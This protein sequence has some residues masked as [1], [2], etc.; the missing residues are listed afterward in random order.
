LLNSPTA[1]AQPLRRSGAL[2]FHRD[3]QRARRLAFIVLVAASLPSAGRARAVPANPEPRL[4]VQPDGVA[5]ERVLRGD[6]HDSRFETLDGFTIVLREEV[7]GAGGAP[8]VYATLDDAGRLAPTELVVGDVDP[9]VLGLV[10]HLSRLDPPAPPPRSPPP[11]SLA[12]DVPAVG[13]GGLQ[14]P[15][16]GS[17]KH[18]V[19]LAAFADHWDYSNVTID[20]RYG[21]PSDRYVALMNER[22]HTADGAVGSVADYYAE[23]TNGQLLVDSKVSGWLRLPASQAVYANADGSGRDDGGRLA[24]DALAALEAAS[25]DFRTVDDDGDGWV[26]MLTIIHSGW[27]AA[28]G[29]NGAAGY[30]WSHASAIDPVVYDG[31]RAGRYTTISALRGADGDRAIVRIG[32]ACHE[33]GHFLGVR[34]FYD[35]DGPAFGQGEGLGSWSVMAGGSWNGGGTRPGPFD[36]YTRSLLGWIVPSRVHSLPPES[37]LVF[38]LPR[39]GETTGGVFRIDDGYA[40]GE[41]LL[42]EHY[43]ETGVFHRFP[44]SEGLA[45]GVAIWHI[46]ERNPTNNKSATPTL[47]RAR[48]VEADGDQSLTSGASRA[49]VGDVWDPGGGTLTLDASHPSGGARANGGWDPGVAVIVGGEP[50]DATMTLATRTKTPHLHLPEGAVAAPGGTVALTWGAA[51]GAAWYDIELGVESPVTYVRD[52][53]ESRQRFLEDWQARGSWQRFDHRGRNAGGAADGDF[54]YAAVGLQ[55][56]SDDAPVIPPVVDFRD[57]HFVLTYQRPLWITAGSIIRW[58]E[59]R[60]LGAGNFA[61]LQ[62]RDWEGGAWTTVRRVEDNAALWWETVEVRGASLGPF[63]GKWVQLRFEVVLDTWAQDWLWPHSGLA[64]DRLELDGVVVHVPTWANTDDVPPTTTERDVTLPQTEGSW[65]LRVVPIAPDGTRGVASNAVR[66]TTSAGFDQTPPGAITNL[67]TTTIGVDAIGLSMT[68]CGD[69]GA[70]GQATLEVRRAAAA[71]TTATWDTTTLIETRAVQGGATVTLTAGGLAPL[72]TW[73]FAAR[74]RDERGLVGP[75]S[76]VVSARTKNLAPAAPTLLGPA[77]GATGV[78]TDAAL[79]WDNGA[80]TADP[81]SATYWSVVVYL[82]TDRG[83]VEGRSGAAAVLVTDALA[84]EHRP[85]AGLAPDTTYHW[86]V[87]DANATGESASAV[88]SFTTRGGDTAAPRAIDDLVVDGVYGVAASLGWTAPGDDGAGGGASARYDLRIARAPIDALGF[89]NAQPLAMSSPAPAGLADGAYLIGLAPETTYWVAVKTEDEVPNVSPISN[90]VSFTTKSVPVPDA[91]TVGSPVDGAAV[92]VTPPLVWVNGAKTGEPPDRARAQVQLFFSQER[93]RVEAMELGA[94]PDAPSALVVEGPATLTTWTPPPLAIRGTYYW[95]VID[96]N[97]GGATVGPVW[98]FRVEAADVIPPRA[99]DDLRV[100]T[101]GEDEVTIAWT[102]PGDDGASG[103][104]SAYEARLAAWSYVAADLRDAP[105]VPDVPAP[106]PGG[107]AST[108]TI[109]GLVPGTDYW[110]VLRAVDEVGGWGG[111]SAVVHF[112]TLGGAGPEPEPEAEPE[113]EPE[114]M[115][116][117]E[118][119]PM[120]EPGPEADTTIGE[121]TSVQVDGGERSD[122]GGCDAGGGADASLLGLAIALARLRA[123]R[124]RAARDR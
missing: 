85:V 15:S 76:N 48:M 104:A 41:Y 37:G 39:S 66:V 89:A 24:R 110:I 50:A 42:V 105:V 100:V 115:I 29:G 57:G 63:V 103:T 12:R 9:W 27:D 46:D 106:L 97:A 87:V 112:R 32:V 83:L 99:I 22:G 94:S 30:V 36:A 23:A 2:A 93:A 95:R 113:A 52:D 81:V 31:V 88:R 92:T 90:V 18:L 34:D 117:P 61:R 51:V 16:F 54:S 1:R 49:E 28:D 11:M 13:P 6:E 10:P 107:S 40:D 67:T 4:T 80:R 56:S 91:P 43:G 26:D 19:I 77:D 70:S 73:F 25:F 17:A 109:E 102:A 62:L 21:L 35:Q 59:K 78:R 124:G 38:P 8:W 71:I 79:T 116:E 64:I 82:S 84:T 123:R 119:E 72:S 58:R 45:E 96:R 120:I 118:A 101:A 114:P 47:L 111:P 60:G 121:D 108:W 14:A 7:P 98:S 86:R 3:M 65:L 75:L 55:W 5:F 53:A 74:C 33:L 69:D 68:A 20:A 44:A 122:D